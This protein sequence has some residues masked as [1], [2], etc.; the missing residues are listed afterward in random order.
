M[1]SLEEYLNE[2]K[3]QERDL[4]L[5]LTGIRANI[6]AIMRQQLGA[7][8]GPQPPSLDSMR[9]RDAVNVYLSWRRDQGMSAATLG[10]LE[11]ELAKHKIVSFRK[12]PM[13]EMRFPWKSMCNALGSPDNKHLYH[14]ERHDPEGHFSR[15]DTIEL[16]SSKKKS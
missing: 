6:D 16:K 3:A 15:A 8:P 10:E 11:K 12:Q 2:L 13:S 1:Q 14:I 7:A 9:I 5:R 4:D